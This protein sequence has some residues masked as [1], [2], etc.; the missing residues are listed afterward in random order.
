MRTDRVE[1]ARRFA[2]IVYWDVAAT[3]AG[4]F[5]L[6]LAFGFLQ[7]TSFVTIADIVLWLWLA[8]F[9]SVPILAIVWLVRFA[10]LASEAG[11]L[12]TTR[13]VM[14]ALPLICVMLVAG[15]IFLLVQLVKGLIGFL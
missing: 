10:T 1:K 13:I 3:M 11:E 7:G 8:I 5:V 4:I 9:F 15:F 12:R 6:W 2:R 14:I